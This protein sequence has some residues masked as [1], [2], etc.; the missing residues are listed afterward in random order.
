MKK[1]ILCLALVVA[2]GAVVGVSVSKE[3]ALEAA[4][5]KLSRLSN[6]AFEAQYEKT[7]AYE[8]V[9]VAFFYSLK[10]RGFMLCSADDELPPLIAY[11]LESAISSID[12]ERSKWQ[13]FIGYDLI[14]RLRHQSNSIASQNRRMWDKAT[15]TNRDFEQ[16]P[17]AGYSPT[18]GWLMSNWTQNSPYNMYCPIDPVANVRSVAGCPSVA[19]GMIVNYYETFNGTQFTDADDYYH[20]YAGR[21]FYIDDD[22]EARGFASFPQLN[23]YLAECLQRYKD[24][25]PIT[26]SDKGA[27]VW[28]CGVACRQ[29]YSSSGSGTF[30]VNQAMQAYQRF[31]FE[32]MELL[33]DANPDL[34]Q[35]IAANM[36]AAMPVHLAI[37]TPAWDAGHNVVVDGYNTDEYYHLNFGWGGSYNGWY[38][39]P[40]EIPYNLTVIEGAIVDI[41]PKSYLFTMPDVVEVLTFQVAL[42]PIIV[43]AINISGEDLQIEALDFP[44]YWGGAMWD[45]NIQGLPELPYNLPAGQSMFIQINVALPIRGE[46]EIMRNDLRIIHSDGVYKLPIVFD[47]DL[48][49]AVDDFSQIPNPSQISTYPNPFVDKLKIRIETEQKQGTSLNIYNLRGQQVKTFDIS[50]KSEILWDGKSLSGE[51]LPAGIYLLKVKG[52]T[53]SAVKRILKL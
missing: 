21:N 45:I 29:V 33:T 20:S 28:A 16:F 42:N 12:Q 6:R 39:L 24:G 37:V 31:A 40:S 25:L 14:Q 51:T 15:G 50:G 10:P 30:S 38:L 48:V 41:S 17:P 18:G 8:D 32:G 53:F 46:R 35:R 1:L 7:I 4:T 22:Y 49:S 3:I 9:P 23:G 27:I 26:N 13:E 11:S 52:S 2:I 5:A 34:Y 36:M 43:E 44:P 47:S 19:M